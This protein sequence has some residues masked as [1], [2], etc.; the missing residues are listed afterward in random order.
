MRKREA[1][2][3]PGRDGDGPVDSGRDDTVDDFRLRE[4]ADRGLVLGR[5]DRAPIRVLEAGCLRVSVARDD[6]E[7]AVAG[8]A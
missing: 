3:D 6:E 1:G 5:D 8:G 2:S 7:P 4:F